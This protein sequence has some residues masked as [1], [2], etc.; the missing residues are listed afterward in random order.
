MEKLNIEV[1]S[2]GTLV[3]M[4]VESTIQSQII[5][6]QKLNKGI[7]HIR[8][9]VVTGKA[10]CFHID[11][12]GV[13]WFKNCLVVPKVPELRQQILDEAHLSQ[14]SI[15]LGSNKMYHDLK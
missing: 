7:D 11:D 12:N 4:T 8:E 6:A 1:V 9:R 10:P 3:T 14:F 2:Q 15:H 5:D 13:L